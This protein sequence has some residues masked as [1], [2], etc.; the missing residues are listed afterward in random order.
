MT[1]IE[2]IL[3]GLIQGLTGVFPV[4][5]SGHLVI[6]R[7]LLGLSGDNIMLF[8]VLLHTGTL[9]AVFTSFRKDI[10]RLYREILLFFDHLIYNGKTAYRNIRY[11]EG[12]RYKRAAKSNYRKLLF[13]LLVSTL[14][15][16]LIA[17]ICK[18]SAALSMDSP[19][20]AGI[21]FYVS[22]VLLIVV[23]F[24]GE[25]KKMPRDTGWKQ[26]VLIGVM[27][28]CT[29]YAGVSRIAITIC[30][31]LLLGYSRKFAIKYSFLLS[32]PTV[33]LALVWEFK[34][35]FGN[36]LAVGEF[37]VMIPGVL[38]SALVG[39]FMI[40]YALNLMK[41]FPLRSFAIYSFIIGSCALI[42]NFV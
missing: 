30:I 7:K 34:E 38:I 24:T 40:P 23:D 35:V 4:S 16:L 31:G 9:A 28:G 1:I 6:V 27:Q 33:I 12:A 39:S 20:A 10:L 11:R 3:L 25:G 17:Y 2:S 36:H 19:L 14:P 29:V 37:L 15:T 18:E 21:G 26:A 8:N 13:I 5:S 41:K 22:C 42:I 32:L